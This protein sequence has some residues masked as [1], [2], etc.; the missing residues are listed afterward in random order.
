MKHCC[1]DTYVQ[2]LK[3]VI[4][5]INTC[6]HKSF[7]QLIGVLQFAVTMIESQ[8]EVGEITLNEEPK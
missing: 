5:H 4:H 6:K 7:S 2:T 3:E 1:K 8:G